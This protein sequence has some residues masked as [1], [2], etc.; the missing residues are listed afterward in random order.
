MTKKLTKG[1]YL[2]QAIKLALAKNLGS[3]VHHVIVHHEAQCPAINGGKTCT[4][5]PTVTIAGAKA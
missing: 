5:K 3:G 1:G 4:C 2:E